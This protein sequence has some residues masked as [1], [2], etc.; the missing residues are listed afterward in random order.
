MTTTLSLN[1]LANLHKTD[2]G[3]GV[4]DRHDY[5]S[6][7]EALLRTRPAFNEGR[8]ALLEIGLW[9]L[10]NPGA[11]ARMWRAFLGPKAT[12]YGIDVNSDCAVLRAEC[13]MNVVLVN[14]SDTEKLAALSVGM[15]LFDMVVDDGSHL[16]HHQM[17]ALETLW[18]RVAQGG[19]YAVEDLHAPQ[20]AGKPEFD[21][22]V[23][24]R[25]GEP[26]RDPVLSPSL[27]I[28]RKGK[29]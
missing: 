6:T 16:G 15:P 22:L 3:D 9:D 14:Q 12:L 8:I 25:M 20:S 11:S 24:D 18:P 21:A 29:R 4:W 28:A 10:R 1:E 27:W 19:Y 23:R 13:G 26:V 17:A 7:Y 2:K 5:A